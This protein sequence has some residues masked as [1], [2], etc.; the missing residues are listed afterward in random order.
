MADPRGGV[1]LDREQ[2]WVCPNCTA[3]E[4]THHFLKP[5]EFASRFHM[6]RGNRGVYAPMVEDGIRC[7]VEVIEREDF[8]GE[9]IVQTDIDGRPIMSTV[10][11]RDDGQD[12]VVYAPTATARS[13]NVD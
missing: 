3:T 13:E 2:R 4:V 1:I 12:C 5:G 6:C 9:D 8:V 11:T 7:K 10:T